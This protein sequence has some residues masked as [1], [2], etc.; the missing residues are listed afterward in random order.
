MMLD[1]ILWLCFDITQWFFSQ[2]SI[3]IEFHI[4]KLE[5]LFGSVSCWER[6]REN[7]KI[8]SIRWLLLMILITFCENGWTKLFTLVS[9]SIWM[10]CLNIPTTFRYS[11]CHLP[12]IHPS[13]GSVIE[14]WSL[15]TALQRGQCR[16][17]YLLSHLLVT[18]FH[19]SKLRM[20]K[21][22]IEAFLTK[23]EPRKMSIFE[24]LHIFIIIFKREKDS[25]SKFQ[26]NNVINSW[27]NA[28]TLPKIFSSIFFI[29]LWYFYG[30]ESRWAIS[31]LHK[32]G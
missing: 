18:C 26:A 22:C 10:K 32:I 16:S 27:K 5:T 29:I 12:S 15:A 7:E 6:E 25:I 14:N 23:P 2:R 11:Y 8:P 9:H 20:W 21:I 4:I 31:R 1:V 19:F 13:N 30:C 17:Q 24:F 28:I 3:F